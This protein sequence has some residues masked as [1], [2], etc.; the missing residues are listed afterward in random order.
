ME[1]YCD[2]VA[3]SAE[4]ARC[5]FLHSNLK[6]PEPSSRIRTCDVDEYAVYK[7]FSKLGYRLR[8]KTERVPLLGKN[9]DDELP[10]QEEEMKTKTGNE[11]EEMD[12][13]F[14]S[15]ETGTGV[16][17]KDTDRIL[18]FDDNEDLTFQLEGNPKFLESRLGLKRKATEPLSSV[19]EGNESDSSSSSVKSMRDATVVEDD[20]DC[21]FLEIVGSEGKAGVEIGDCPM[22]SFEEEEENMEAEPV[23][24]PSY[25]VVE[26]DSDSDLE[27]VDEVI[28]SH[29]G[30]GIEEIGYDGDAEN[31]NDSNG[32]CC[33]S[34]VLS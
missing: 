10:V 2:H 20:S 27:I 11:T 5:L 25:T 19:A 28:H 9:P 12:L 30:V 31:I 6:G 14:E 3:I 17:N 7:Y 34:Y 22:S 1:V 18:T 16:P 32:M 21:E 13:E 23:A 4:R 24:G 29:C 33:I 26:A 8:R 15:E